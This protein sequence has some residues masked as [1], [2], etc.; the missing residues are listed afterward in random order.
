LGWLQ[1]K[2]QP[3]RL[4]LNIRVVT[5]SVSDLPTDLAIQNN[6]LCVPTIMIVEGRN[7]E[8]GKGISREEL[9]RRLP[10]MQTPPSTGAPSIGS[11]ENAYRE[12]FKEGVDKI[13][14][15]DTCKTDCNKT[16]QKNV[17]N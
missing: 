14:F 12:L 9:Y 7:L 2:I 17:L 4:E 3:G 10:T 6:I 5:D 15:N 8:D 16:V 11:I 1:W 13:V